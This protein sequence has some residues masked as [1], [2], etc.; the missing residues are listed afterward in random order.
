MKFAVPVIVLVLTLAACAQTPMGLVAPVSVQAGGQ[1]DEFRAEDFT[2]STEQGGASISGVM[3]YHTGEVRYS[4]EGSDVRL[5][6]ETPWSRRRMVILYGTAS[7]GSAPVSI[8]RARTPSAPT[9]D[10]ARFVRK[11]TCNSEN[12]FSFSGLPRGS[13]FVITVAKPV[14]GQG[15]AIALT[16]RVETRGGPK[17]ITLN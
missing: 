1:E 17:T 11:T 16:R 9:G 4:C 12:Q 2:W 8:V 15:E 6:P 13:W 5:T 3:T 7:A 10:F 14:N